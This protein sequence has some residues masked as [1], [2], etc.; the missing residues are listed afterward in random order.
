[1]NQF[2]E[3][4]LSSLV[5]WWLVFVLLI[6]RALVRYSLY[7]IQFSQLKVYIQYIH[8]NFRTFSLPQKEILH[9]LAITPQFSHPPKPQA[10]TNLLLVPMDLFILNISLKWSHIVCDP[11]GWNY[12]NYHN[13]FKIHLCCCTFVASFIGK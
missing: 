1:M 3:L 5:V 8:H 9:P 2:A 6:L 7:S 10:S 11:L 4:E 13:V 12:F